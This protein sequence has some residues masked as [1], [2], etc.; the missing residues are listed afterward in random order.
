[1]KKTLTILSTILVILISFKANAQDDDK[2]QVKSYLGII[3]GLSY[4][5]GNFASSNYSNNSSGFA[6]RGVALGLDA[7]I[8]LYKNFGIGVTAAFQDQ[9]ELNGGDAQALSNGYNTSYNKDN[10]SVTTVDRYHIFSLMA[11]PQYSRIIKNFILDFRI[12]AGMMKSSSTPT[13]DVIFDSSSVTSSELDQNSSGAWAFA[14]GASAGLRWSFSENWDLGFKVNYINSAGF[15]VSNSSI[16]IP[17]DNVGR[18][19]TKIPVSVIQPTL[20]ITLHL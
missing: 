14:Y 10:T 4:P 18:L 8:Y 3:G 1:M 5:G 12:S 2:P 17:D 15:G 9:G 7:G 13:V 11:G 19:V 20:G 16:G 6:K